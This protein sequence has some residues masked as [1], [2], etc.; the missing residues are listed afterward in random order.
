VSTPRIAIK[1]SG[2]EATTPSMTPNKIVE[3]IFVLLPI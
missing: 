3:G 1:N 2:K